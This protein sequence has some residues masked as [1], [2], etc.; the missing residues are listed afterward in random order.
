MRQSTQAASCAA[1]TRHSPLNTLV[2]HSIA[3]DT[4][5][6][7]AQQFVQRQKVMSLWRDCMRTIYSQLSSTHLQVSALTSHQKSHHRTALEKKCGLSPVRN[8]IDI[9]KST[10]SY[11]T[12][13][14]L[15]IP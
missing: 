10:I 15:Q 11:A 6:N 7:Q 12:H 1:K 13:P 4:P 5:I 9:G 3:F 2:P 8:L 14:S